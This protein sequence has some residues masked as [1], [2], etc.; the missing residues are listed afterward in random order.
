M[1]SLYTLSNMFAQLQAMAADDD[2]CNMATAVSETMAALSGDVE[3]AT[4]NAVKLIKNLDADADAIA[5]EIK[6]LSERKKSIENSI[7]QLRASV[8]DVMSLAS[9]TQIK[10]PLFTISL[11]RG[12]ESCVIENENEIPAEFVEIIETI[13]PNKKAILSAIN[14]GIAVPGCVVAVG[15]LSLRIK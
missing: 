13:K 4:E 5:A 14:S 2:S 10:T 9:I 12:R 3:F 6:R 1:A 15:D 11:A 7:T 8:V